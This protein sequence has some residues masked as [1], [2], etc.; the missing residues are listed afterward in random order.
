MHATITIVHA[1]GIGPAAGIGP[2]PCYTI[3]DALALDSFPWLEAFLGF[4]LA[5]AALHVWLDVRQL[6]VRDPARAEIS[7]DQ[8][9]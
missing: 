3:M 1:I 4:H 9:R 6:R 5:V 8:Q 2:A 7:R